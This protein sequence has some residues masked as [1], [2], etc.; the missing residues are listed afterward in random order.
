MAM[1]DCRRDTVMLEA[2]KQGLRL[3]LGLVVIITVVTAHTSS[4]IGKVATIDGKNTLVGQAQSKI[5]MEAMRLNAEAGELFAK[6]RYDEAIPLAERALAMLE[7]ALGLD[8]PEV[9][10]SL[11]NLAVLYR[12]IGDYAKAEPLFHRALAILEKTL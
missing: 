4:V 1:P 6:G 10:K 2:C 5:L 12:T 7:K 9:A 11:H 8:Q 3:G